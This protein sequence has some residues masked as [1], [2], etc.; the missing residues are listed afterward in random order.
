MS[1]P[2]NPRQ[3]FPRDWSIGALD[4]GQSL[5]QNPHLTSWTVLSSHPLLEPRPS[6]HDL[7]DVRDAVK[8]VR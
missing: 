6:L 1:E 2:T 5:L 4:T 8:Y 3:L 7:R